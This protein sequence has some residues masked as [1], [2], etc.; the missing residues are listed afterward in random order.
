MYLLGYDL[1]SSSIKAALIDS[2]TGE[3][4]QVVQYPETEM[5][6]IS[7]QNGWAEQEPETWWENLCIATKELLQK[8]GVNPQEIKS[9]GIAYQ[10][11]G[12]VLVDKDQNVLRPSIIWCDS[13]A[14]DIGNEAFESLGK[15]KCLSHLLNSPGNFTASKLKWVKDNEPEIFD[16]IDKIMLPGDYIAMKLSGKINTT[17]SGLSEGMFWDFKNNKIADFLIDHYGISNTLIPNVVDTFEVQGYVSKQA[18]IETGLS[19]GTAVAYRAGDQPNNALSLGV[20]KPNEVAATGGTSGVVYGMADKLIY[21]NESRI[22]GFAH[23]NHSIQNPR[24]G[25]LLCINGAGIQHSWLKKQMANSETSYVEMERMASNIP[26]GADGL[27][28]LPFGNGSERML[29]NSNPGAQINNLQFNKHT[30]AHF[31]RAG[32]EGIAFAFV[33]GFQVLKDLGMNPKVIK[34]GNDNL[35]QSQVFS[36]TIANLLGCNIEVIK[37]TG[38]AGAAKASGIGVGIYSSLEDASKTNEIE[39]VYKPRSSNESYFIA[40]R[41]W[42]SDLIKLVSK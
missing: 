36:N 15:E 13:R 26:I 7:V 30:R 33:H 29:K 2:T 39:K 32:L 3:T 17:I 35:F 14:V 31:Y 21:D 12:L 19:D 16:E 20:F 42:G 24:L 28:I 9:I 18:A 23:V 40:Y 41:A 8:S 38:A 22:N 5:D 27:R 6:I 1:G 10:M 34:V 37:T 25:L 11:H 4:V